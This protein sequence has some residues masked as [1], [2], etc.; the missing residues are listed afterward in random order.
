MVRPT[1]AYAKPQTFAHFR[2]PILV[3][4]QPGFYFRR[5]HRSGSHASFQLTT[6]INSQVQLIQVQLS[7]SQINFAID[8]TV[9]AEGKAPNKSQPRHQD[10]I[11]YTRPPV[12]AQDVLHLRSNRSSS[13]QPSLVPSTEDLELFDSC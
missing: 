6:L 13:R 7:Y 10:P 11:I 1:Y 4:F 2:F 5:G 8:V 9:L 12:Q 3:Y